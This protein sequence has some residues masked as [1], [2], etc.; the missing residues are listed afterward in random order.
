MEKLYGPKEIGAKMTAAKQDDNSWRRRVDKKLNDLSS[1]YSDLNSRLD[2]YV[3]S[4]DD[5]TSLTK[6]I[7]KK[8]DDLIAATAIAVEFATKASKT[9][10]VFSW[11]GRQSRD[12]AI[13]L[14]QYGLAALVILTL[15]YMYEHATAGGWIKSFIAVFNGNV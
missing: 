14:G 12:I 2:T 7:D 1:N 13:A 5:N 15:I 11:L 3:K 4:M 9:G 8:L 10:K 6:R